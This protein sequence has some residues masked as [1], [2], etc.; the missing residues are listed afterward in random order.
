MDRLRRRRG[1]DPG[2]GAWRP[3]PRGGGIRPRGAPRG[4]GGFSLVELVVAVMILSVG[5]LALA[6]GMGVV[7][8]SVTQSGVKTDRSA[9]LQSGLET[10]KSMDFDD[11][12]SGA[13]SVGIYEVRWE[14][15]LETQNWK[16]VN[17][18][19]EGPAASGAGAGAPFVTRSV[20]DTFSYTLVRP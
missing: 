8:G 15:V 13:D 9:A 1:R 16:D 10:V 7:V 19:V 3:A 14:T 4:D 11:V 12:D 2:R 6:G 17:V 20:T 5:L 18:T